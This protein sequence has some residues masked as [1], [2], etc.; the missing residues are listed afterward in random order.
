MTSYWGKSTKSCMST[1]EGLLEA[2]SSFPRLYP[3]AF[4]L[5]DFAWYPPTILNDT[6][7]M[8]VS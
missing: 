7:S 1:R 2:V 6:M 5:D 3:C 4:P 8:T